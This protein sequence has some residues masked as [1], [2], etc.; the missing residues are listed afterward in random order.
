MHEQKFGGDWT[1][2]KLSCLDA[3]LESY[4][5]IFSKNTNAQYFNTW[6]VDAFAGTGSR[7]IDAAT[8]PLW[9]VE[10]DSDID[11]DPDAVAYRDGSA[12]IALGQDSPFDN[13]LFI[14]KSKTKSTA[15]QSAI[16]EKFPDLTSRCTIVRDDANTALTTWV[17]ERNWNKDRAVVFL[18]PF[19][20][21]VN[22]ETVELLGSTGGIDLWYLFPFVARLLKQDGNI[23]DGWRERLTNLLGTDEWF[24]HFYKKTIQPGLFGDYEVTQRDATVEN[25]Q[26]YIHDR[27]K[28]CFVAVAPSM[29]LRNS[30]N[31][32]LFALCFAASNEKGAPIALRIAKSILKDQ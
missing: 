21:Q 24:G 1:D 19:G 7:S 22:W 8:G 28:T 29:I 6:Y 17:K 9:N 12:M 13:Y 15:L 5:S 4:R 32:P 2:L 27:L 14:E 20:M 10:P 26:N 18:D 30:K 11:C 31:S 25:I 23:D 3:Y 16:S